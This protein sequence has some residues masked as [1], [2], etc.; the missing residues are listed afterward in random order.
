MVSYG[1]DSK[2]ARVPEEIILDASVA[3]KW[4]TEEENTDLALKI[5]DRYFEDEL[6]IYAPVLIIYEVE[7]ALRFKPDV[8]ED[9]VNE[10]VKDLLNMELELIAPSHELCT[11]S[12]DLSFEHGISVYDSVYLALA[13]LL[14]AKVVT[15]DARFYRSTEDTG[16]IFKLAEIE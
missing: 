12:I 2:M 16:R 13:E 5:R 7:N 1:G 4:F 14:G 15:D 9:L 8:N 3:V 6:M 10:W 11:L